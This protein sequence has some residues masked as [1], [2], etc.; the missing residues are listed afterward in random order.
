MKSKVEKRGGQYY[1]YNLGLLMSKVN[2]METGDC[3]GE[4]ALL[5][6]KENEPRMATVLCTQDCEFA[7]LDRQSFQ[8][9]LE[10]SDNFRRASFE[11]S[12]R[13]SGSARSIS[14]NGATF[15]RMF[16]IGSLL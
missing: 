9:K 11:D 2:Q 3:F 16:K 8:V 1:I 5:S 6:N 10:L 7:V 13:R 12:Q 4:L 14:N 15:E